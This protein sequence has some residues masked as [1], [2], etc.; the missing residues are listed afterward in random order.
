MKKFQKKLQELED[1]HRL[2]TLKLPNG[3][4]LTSNDY[5]GFRSHPLLRK[6]AIEAL[7]NGIDLGSGGSRLLRGHTQAH[8]DLEEFA[9]TYFGCEK[10]LYFATGFLANQAIFTTLP[11]RH[12]LIIFD[13]YIHASVREGIQNSHA[14][15][16]KIPH[17]DVNAFEDVLKISQGKYEAVWI[18]AESVYS[19]DGDLAPLQEIFK[20]TQT[21]N[22]MLVIDE[23][24]GTGVFGK[25]GKGVSEDMHSANVIT[26]HTCG[27]A[28]GV[29]GGLVTGAREIIDTLVNRS[30][31]FIYS[32]APIPLQCVMVQRAL[33]LSRDE[34]W[35]REKLHSLM[36]AAKRL[37]PVEN[38]VS[39][40]VPIVIGEDVRAVEVATAM[41][42]AGYDVRAIRPPT[43][44]EGT[45]R[46]R[47]SLNC[48]ISEETLKNFADTL[49]PFLQ[50][51]TLG[52]AA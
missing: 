7:E 4:D 48:N 19:M 8:Q 49:A 31:G 52:K 34:P 17:N 6:A 1:Q 16:V 13:E 24:H 46:L 23:A 50:D 36:G 43:V 14:K 37:L 45:A 10:A 26:L 39:Q 28:L 21:Y 35:R 22:A 5:L 38:L 47:V 44:P 33:E 40:I 9:A 41:Q 25:S 3:I 18:A 51:V 20:L 29:A 32:T 30:R 42:Q 12:D 15:H 27:K 11:G 2:R